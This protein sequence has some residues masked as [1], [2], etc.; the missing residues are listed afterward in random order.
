MDN[1]EQAIGGWAQEAKK[2]AGWLIVL[3]IVTTIG[4]CWPWRR[5]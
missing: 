1:I 2:N 4:V 3:G 5:P